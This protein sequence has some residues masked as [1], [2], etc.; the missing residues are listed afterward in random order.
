MT[1]RDWWR[2]FA[3]CKDAWKTPSIHASFFGETVGE[4]RIAKTI[5]ETCPHAIK[6]ACL[7]D[8]LME[9]TGVRGGLGVRERQRLRIRRK[10]YF[11]ADLD[12]KKAR[13]L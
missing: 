11:L 4:Q 13:L 1:D 2:E 8:G 9:P 7:E 5:C 6:T 10:Q 3:A 12:P